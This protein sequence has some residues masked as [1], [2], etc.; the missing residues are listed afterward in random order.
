MQ[1]TCQATILKEIKILEL[2]GDFKSLVVLNLSYNSLEGIVPSS[3]GNLRDLQLLDL[4]NN[5]LSGE[6]PP[7]LR[8]MFSYFAIQNLKSKALTDTALTRNW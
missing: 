6:I 2:I 3:L 1:R 8:N 5:N 4:S 7:E